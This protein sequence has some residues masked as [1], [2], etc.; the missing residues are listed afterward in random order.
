MSA[1]RDAKRGAEDAFE[2]KSDPLVVELTS[3]PAELAVSVRRG[4]VILEFR[5]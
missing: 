2:L 3:T 1:K 4:R 5:M